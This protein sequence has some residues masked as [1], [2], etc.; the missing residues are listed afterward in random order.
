M[1]QNYLKIII[2]NIDLKIEDLNHEF[3]NLYQNIIKN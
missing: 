1:I 2:F 3:N